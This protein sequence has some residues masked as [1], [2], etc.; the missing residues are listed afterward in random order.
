MSWARWSGAGILTAGFITAIGLWKYRRRYAANQSLTDQTLL[1]SETSPSP[2]HNDEGPCA[3]ELEPLGQDLICAILGNLDVRCAMQAMAVST[4]FETAVRYTLSRQLGRAAGRIWPSQTL[5][6]ASWCHIGAPVVWHQLT[7]EERERRVEQLCSACRDG[8]LAAAN[9]VF[10]RAVDLR[11]NCKLPDN[12]GMVWADTPLGWAVDGSHYDVL[13]LLL[14]RQA[15]PNQFAAHGT[16][17]LHLAA[18][19]GDLRSTQL[20]VQFGASISLKSRDGR[21][22]VAW[23][24][25]VD[26]TYDGPDEARKLVREWL[27][28]QLNNG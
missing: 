28:N 27:E 10:N 17:P 25:G 9:A 23:A 16:C 7:E 3:L 15:D 1:Q 18:Q 14:V 22:A 12:N 26:P 5:T 8:D 6:M 11:R 4:Q 21:D 19:K 13:Q 2:D 20:L 24:S